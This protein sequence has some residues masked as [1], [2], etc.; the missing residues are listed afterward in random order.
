MT[1]DTPEDCRNRRF[2]RRHPLGGQDCRDPVNFCREWVA[3]SGQSGGVNTNLNSSVS[4]VNDVSRFV[5]RLAITALRFRRASHCSLCHASAR[6]YRGSALTRS[7][8]GEPK[9]H[10]A[11]FD[12][13]IAEAGRCRIDKHHGVANVEDSHQEGPHAIRSSK[14]ATRSENLVHLGKQ[15]ILQC[16]RGQVMKHRE[17]DCAREDIVGQLHRC[18]MVDFRYLIP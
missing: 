12:F 3:Q 10:S 5:I 2:L 1:S 7:R 9:S 14:N 4:V 18:R 15:P 16:R 8:G 11:D 13:H 6:K 17:A